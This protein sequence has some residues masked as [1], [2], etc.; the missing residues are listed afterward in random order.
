MGYWPWTEE[1]ARK[2]N[3]YIKSFRGFKKNNNQTQEVASI[4]EYLE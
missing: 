1:I 2:I 4:Y 3:S